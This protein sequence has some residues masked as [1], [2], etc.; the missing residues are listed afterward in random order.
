VSDWQVYLQEQPL[1]CL[2]QI[3]ASDQGLFV[4]VALTLTQLTDESGDPLD[5]WGDLRS[6]VLAPT[7]TAELF[8]DPDATTIEIIR[9]VWL[10]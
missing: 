3:Q 9:M 6:V 8:A 1:Q 4:H 5:A 10:A 2:N 7:V